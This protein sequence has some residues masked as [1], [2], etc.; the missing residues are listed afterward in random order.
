MKIEW[1]KGANAPFCVAAPVGAAE[2]AH[3]RTYGFRKK[4]KYVSHRNNIIIFE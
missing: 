2:M 1:Q 3:H 4:N